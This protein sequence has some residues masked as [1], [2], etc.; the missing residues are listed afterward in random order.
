VWSV[1]WAHK[2]I[3]LRSVFLGIMGFEVFHQNRLRQELNRIELAIR[4][5]SNPTI[6]VKVPFE[7]FIYGQLLY[8]GGHAAGGAVG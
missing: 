6:S 3:H 1:L 5:T 4:T 7:Y 8:N 2:I